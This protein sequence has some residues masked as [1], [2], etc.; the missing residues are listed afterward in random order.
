M[1]RKLT[2][3]EEVTALRD[4]IRQ[5]HEVTQA[6]NA[7]PKEAKNLAPD[8]TRK[9]EQHCD[10]EIKN[11][12]NKMVIYSNQAA[13]NLN[14]NVEEA[15]RIITEQ[16]LQGEVIFDVTQGVARISFGAMRFDDAQPPPYPEVT[17]RKDTP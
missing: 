1:G 7:S 8:L 15:R 14:A 17:S 5:A 6:L 13:A 9:F 16:I 2:P 3:T 11:L 4:L 12:S 10:M